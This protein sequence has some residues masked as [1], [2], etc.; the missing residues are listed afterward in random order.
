MDPSRRK[1]ISGDWLKRAVADANSVDA[2]TGQNYFDSFESCYPL[3]AS[4]GS[5]L[6]DEAL[7][8][9]I[10]PDGKS[11]E[12]VARELFERDFIY[13]NNDAERHLPKQR[14]DDEY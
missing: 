1:L 9:G 6:V 7:A 13:P 3:L 5:L 10:E 14:E 2:T 8:K 4:A 12:A 11:L